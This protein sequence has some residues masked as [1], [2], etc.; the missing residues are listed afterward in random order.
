MKNP[1]KKCNSLFSQRLCTSNDKSCWRWPYSE[2][3]VSIHNLQLNTLCVSCCDDSTTTSPDLCQ[4]GDIDSR[5]TLDQCCKYPLVF[6]NDINDSILDALS[7][8]IC[9]LGTYK[10]G[11][12]C[13]DYDTQCNG[14]C[15]GNNIK[16]GD[17]CV[18]NKTMLDRHICT[19]DGV[20]ECLSRTRMCNGQCP[21]DTFQCGAECRP[22]YYQSWY[23]TCGE[24]CITSDS[25]CEGE[26]PVGEF[27]CGDKCRREEDRDQYWECDGSCLYYFYPCNGVCQNNTQSCGNSNSERQLCLPDDQ[28]WL[29]D[30]FRQ[31]GD[32]C[33]NY[34]SQCNGT[35]P[36]G[37]S[38]CGKYRCISDEEQDDYFTCND[39]C[40]HKNEFTDYYYRL[41]GE[42]C[43]HR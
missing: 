31:C 18:S 1:I 37:F 24:E 12:D 11:T 36:A 34:L 16:C 7:E 17:E 6:S 13:V 15:Y 28:P 27:S 42:E 23:Q 10:C 2:G 9:G 33:I 38:P 43:L 26:C 5:E 35:C 20:T 8:G 4:C 3:S 19:T 25:A 32:E 40:E 21:E 22:N 29:A 39:N 41:C 14:T 30:S